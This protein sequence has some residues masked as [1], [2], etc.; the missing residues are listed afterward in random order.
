MMIDERH[1]NKHVWALA[2]IIHPQGQL[3]TLTWIQKIL[4]HYDVTATTIDGSLDLEN[5]TDLWQKLLATEIERMDA[6]Q[7]KTAI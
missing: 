1:I 2:R 6:L 4:A 3:E 5:A 7:R